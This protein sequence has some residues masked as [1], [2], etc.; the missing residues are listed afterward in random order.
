MHHTRTVQLALFLIV[1]AT[2]CVGCNEPSG[3][4]PPGNKAITATANNSKVSANPTSNQLSPSPNRSVHPWPTVG[5]NYQRT[6]CSPFAGP[7]HPELKWSAKLI[8]TASFKKYPL[9]SSPL[10]SNDGNIYIQSDRYTLNAISKEGKLLWHTSSTG[11]WHFNQ[12]FIADDGALLSAA[13]TIY[14][15]DPVTGA[16]SHLFDQDLDIPLV[17][18]RK[19][20]YHLL[21]PL[22][23]N[24]LVGLAV[25]SS[26]SPLEVLN[27][28]SA[29]MISLDLQ[30]NVNWS[31]PINVTS[32]GEMALG[33][34]RHFYLLG[35][36][37]KLAAY[38]QTGSMLWQL[39]S[40]QPVW[41]N[42]PV[43][44]PDGTILIF[45][46][47]TA[48]IHCIDQNGQQVWMQKFPDWRVKHLAVTKTGLIVAGVYIP[49][50]P[51][52]DNT[53]L[54]KLVQISPDGS[55]VWEVP[56][57]DGVGNIT[58]DKT[59]TIYL[60]MT[61][62]LNAYYPD[63]TIKWHLEVGK[64]T[65]QASIGEDGTIYALGW[66]AVLYAIGEAD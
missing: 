55:I 40:K 41:S 62:G 58:I 1:L 14:R 3:E 32:L 34:N 13:D 25:S 50:N 53:P 36:L 17:L 10:I 51:H 22:D 64:L 43:V 30:G 63:G 9:N 11:E 26:E 28:C 45:G 37:G 5:Q 15:V 35:S 33:L 49:P 2:L 59:G 42:S 27:D 6:S 12:P 21:F 54:G 61:D 46:G 48:E 44:A 60:P 38:D 4:S 66:N 20:Q 19:E 47:S 65:K 57:G 18:E 29:D 8:R 24:T 56:T 39:D 16:L 23:A 52:S 31:V 7:E